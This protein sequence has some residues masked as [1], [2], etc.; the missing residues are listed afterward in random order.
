MDFSIL[1]SC[2]G[3]C[4][5]PAASISTSTS[6]VS[7]SCTVSASRSSRRPPTRSAAAFPT[8]TRSIRIQDGG[9]RRLEGHTARR[10]HSAVSAWMAT[11]CT[12]LHADHVRGKVAAMDENDRY[13]NRLP[14]KRGSWQ[15]EG[16]GL[17]HRYEDLI[18]T[19]R[20]HDVIPGRSGE[21]TSRGRRRS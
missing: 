9:L 3:I 11:V 2:L 15:I 19:S 7:D 1:D 14:R 17:P 16:L 12:Q 5:S 20:L 13:S 6:S 8:S 18:E 21:R 4:R 10:I